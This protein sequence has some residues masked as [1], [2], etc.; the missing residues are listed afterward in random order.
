M[1]YQYLYIQ[2]LPVVPGVS[3]NH[4]M[5]QPMGTWDIAMVSMDVPSRFLILR[6]VAKSPMDLRY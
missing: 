4:S 3:S 6:V 5:N 2:Y 1:I